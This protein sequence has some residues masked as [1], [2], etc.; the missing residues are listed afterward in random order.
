VKAEEKKPD[1]A[2]ASP[3]SALASYVLDAVPAD[4]PHPLD[5]DFEH[6]A[7]LVG[8]GIEPA[9]ARPGRSLKLTFFWRCDEAL[10][11]EG[12][13]AF[14]HIADESTGKVDNLDFAGPLREK[15]GDHQALGPGRW[16]KG[17]FY[18]DEQ[19]YT[20]PE[21]VKGP[22]TVMLG[23][24]KG[25]ARLLVL[26]GAND[27]DNRAIVAKVQV[28][29]NADP[30]AVPADVA[31]PPAKA[32]RTASGLAYRVLIPGTGTE[33]PTSTSTVTVDYT[34][35]TT[36]GKMF[37][38]SVV[39][40]QPASFRL[41]SVIKG[42]TEGV[43]LMTKGEKARFW[44]PGKLAYGDAPGRPGTPSGMLVFEVELLEVR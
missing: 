25:T 24:W 43:Q 11:D 34:G 27:G 14:T 6:K 38:S 31:A 41:S 32:R 16:Q 22:L 4:I 12:W 30:P 13:Q 36:D 5:V 29:R 2:P 44:I 35:W 21:D 3:E 17:K 19:T 1:P 33:H 28:A 18:V 37:D 40:G 23:I 15:Q 8:Y 26:S 20:V 7:H 42:W 39:R 9:S 10:G